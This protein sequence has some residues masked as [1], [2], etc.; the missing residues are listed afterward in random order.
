M[1]EL[2][3]KYEKYQKYLVEIEDKKNQLE[4]NLLD[5]ESKDTL[6]KQYAKLQIQSED[7]KEIC[8]RI[9]KYKAELAIIDKKL[10]MIKA[11]TPLV[12]DFN[13]LTNII[14]LIKNN[15]KE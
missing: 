14:K 11:I 7:Y 8:F 10:N 2:L 12:K 4:L 3:Y 13:E 5:W 6:T 9:N 15:P 1:I